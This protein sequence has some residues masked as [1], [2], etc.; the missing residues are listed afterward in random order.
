MLPGIGSVCLFS[1]PQQKK[2]EKKKKREQ[3]KF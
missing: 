3:E 1:R 2:K